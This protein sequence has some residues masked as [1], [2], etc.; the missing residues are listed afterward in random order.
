MRKLI[1]TGHTRGLG[2][3]LAQLYLRQGRQVL[4]LARGGA[5]WRPSENLRQV[6]IDL[7][8][9]AALSALLSDGL[10]RDFLA[11]AEDILLINNAAAVSPNALLGRQR[12]SEIL[13]SVSL[14]IAA[15]L[16]LAN[17]VLAA[18]PAGVPLDILHIGSGAGRKSYAGWS[19]YGATKAAL[20]HHA[21]C[22][23]AEGHA[24][25]RAVCLAPGIV[26]TD[27]QAQ[28]RASDAAAFPLHAHFVSLK[29][30]NS[31]QTAQETAAKIAAY[32]ESP[33]FG[34]D[35]AADIRDICP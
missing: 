28:I 23:A 24:K 32:I 30:Q 35:A 13:A 33:H 12:P 34:K 3:A 5:A 26:D 20:D 19:V 9:G 25:L 7:S 21:R 11:G 6:K 16:L 4:G 14:N 15:P 10:L 27:M 17:A 29:N 31:L 1:I 18:R 22:M 2:A 8:D